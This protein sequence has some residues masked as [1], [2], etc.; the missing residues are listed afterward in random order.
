M[1]EPAHHDDDFGL[2]EFAMVVLLIV[3]SCSIAF[4][5]G[6]AVMRLVLAMFFQG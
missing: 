2:K 5:I 6:F 3:L 4:V 1:H